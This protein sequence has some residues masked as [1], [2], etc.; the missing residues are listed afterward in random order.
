ME[1]RALLLSTLQLG[2]L[3]PA[4]GRDVALILLAFVAPLQLL[5][6]TFGFLGR[7]VVAATAMGVLSGTWLSIG[8]VTLDAAPGSTS[9]ALGLLL[10]LAGAA[11]SIP[12]PARARRSSS[13]PW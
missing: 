2:W 6:A 8:L 12:A 10:L 13:R 11:L 1:R 7:D 4:D 5:A 9:R 3:E